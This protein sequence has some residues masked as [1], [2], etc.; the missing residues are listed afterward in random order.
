VSSPAGFVREARASDAPVLARVQVASWQATLG[1]LVPAE[2]LSELSDEA[3]VE[4]FG[5]RWREAIT[6]PPTSRHK[7]LVAYAAGAVAEPVGFASVGPAT[8]EDRW[9]G[10]DGEL[11][12]LHVLPEDRAGGH[13]GRLLHAAA[14]TLA[15][16][17]FHTACAWV[18][19]ADA[20]R[21]DFLT[22]AG[23]APDGSK[24]NLDMGVK[25]PVLRL[26]TLLAGGTI[27][28]DPPG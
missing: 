17:G 16:D 11:Y 26:H 24:G 19:A 28:Q 2:V 5:E 9:P 21:L 4:Q 27:P 7:V 25:V 1:D 23:W 18:L 20:D 10:T 13:A 8:D 12:E 3:M 14:D 6:S 15:E 22:A